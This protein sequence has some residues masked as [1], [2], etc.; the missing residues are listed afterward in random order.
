MKVAVIGGGASGMMTAVLLARRGVDVTIFEKNNELGKKIL[1]TGKGR[2]NVTNNSTG[3]EFLS[4]VIRGN[5]FLISAEQNFNSTKTIEFFENLGVKLKTE[6]GN[7]VFPESDKAS[8]I[9]SAFLKALNENNVKILKNS[10][11]FAVFCDDNKFKSLQTGNKI[12]DD[13][14]ACVIATGGLSYPTTGSTGDGLKFAES[15]GH[16]IT[17]LRPALNG[18]EVKENVKNLE[19]LSLKNVK[20]FAKFKDKIVFESEIGEMLFT[21]V[22]ISGPLVLTM[23]SFI[24]RKDVDTLSIDFKPALSLDQIQARVDREIQAAPNKQASSLISALLPSR[25]VETFLRTLKID[26]A[27]KLNQLTREKRNQL[28]MLLKNFK[29]TFK[30]IEPIETSVIT[31]GGVNLNEINPKD[32]QSKLI[33]NLFFGGEVLDCD[34]LTGGFNLQIAF[35]TAAACANS[36]VFD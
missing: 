18:I 2:C 23:S 6:R 12:Y 21:G 24:N 14:D 35:M 32:M 25:L 13:F 3:E 30:R 29:L 36:S 15:V 20:V 8:S 31:S 17:E 11:V 19:G 16:N 22:G 33:K 27:I 34:A 5:K 28:A 7:R 10:P 9:N 4:N 1:I 26:K